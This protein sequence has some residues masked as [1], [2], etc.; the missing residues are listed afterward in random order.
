MRESHLDPLQL[1]VCRARTRGLAEE[2]G[3]ELEG[4]KGGREESEKQD[5]N[6]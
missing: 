4:R 3:R 6:R 1:P 5:G 2:R